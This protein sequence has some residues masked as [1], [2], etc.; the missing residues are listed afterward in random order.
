MLNS[1]VIDLIGKV[2]TGP[3]FYLGQEKTI[4]D[5][6]A[7]KKKHLLIRNGFARFVTRICA[8]HFSDYE[9]NRKQESKYALLYKAS[10][11]VHLLRAT[12]STSMVGLNIDLTNCCCSVY[13]IA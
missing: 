9:R 4:F 7:V 10:F 12:S 6:I 2:V 8:E 1:N 3:L 13:E 11:P 5:T